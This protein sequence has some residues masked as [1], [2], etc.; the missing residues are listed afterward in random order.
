MMDEVPL[1]AEEAE[2][3]PE[4]TQRLIEYKRLISSAWEQITNLNRNGKWH[5]LP[6]NNKHE[7][8]KL[9]E[10]VD[11]D[12]RFV[13]KAEGKLHAPMDRIVNL[14][15]DTSMV[16]RRQWEMTDLGGIQ[17]WESFPAY[18]INVV[19]FWVKPP[20]WIANLGV[21]DRDFLG[22][23][24]HRHVPAKRSHTIIFQTLDRHPHHKCPPN[25][26]AA[27]GTTYMWLTEIDDTKCVVDILVYINLG[28]MVPE[29]VITHYK[30]RLRERLYYYQQ[31]ANNDALYKSIYDPWKCSI[32]CAAIRAQDLECRR[33]RI[34]RY[35]R[36]SDET[37]R[38]PMYERDQKCCHVCKNKI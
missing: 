8:I 22:L 37:C 11:T 7:H 13:I 23:Q 9:F 20:K 33:C 24:W 35:G 12:G 31:V 27:R 1:Q 18:N 4:D 19:Q 16:T 10:T 36:C 6:D 17:E 30:E 3:V 25:R 34:A 15:L 26:A 29:V 5:P 2:S 38:E 14:N 32:C 28:G 21:W